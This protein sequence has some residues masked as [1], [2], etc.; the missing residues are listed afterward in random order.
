MKLLI[1]GGAGYVGS[2]MVRYAQE[3]GHEVVVLDD[4]STGNKWAVKDCEILNINLLDTERLSKLMKGRFFDG[5]IHFAAKSLVGESIKR[6]KFYFQNN[7]GGTLNLVSEMLKN[8]IQNIV[9]SSTAAIFGNPETEK[10]SEDHPKIPINPYGKSKLMVEIF[11]KNIS[12]SYDLNVTCLRY[13]NAAGA[14][15]SGE[16]GEARSL[17]THLIPS[18]LNSV[19]FGKGDFKIF[20]NDYP[21][22]DG[23]CIRD[24][25]HVTDLAKAHLLALKYMEKNKGFSAFNL[26]NGNG[27]SI[28]EIISII[29]SCLGKAVN[30]EI[31]ERR[32]GDPPI[33][34][35]NSIEAENKLGWKPSYDSTKSIIDSA[36][37]WHKK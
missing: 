8:D 18:I 3:H 29:E 21:T 37:N 14:H 19:L 1:P 2:H 27:T 6:S 28:L 13:F 4:F 15:V 16:I 32:A 34:V 31:A 33:L 11:L 25:I 26:G 30:Y 23:T 10:I 9:F 17:E 35:A 7:I 20:G 24:Y 12:E 36:I 22:F 5:I